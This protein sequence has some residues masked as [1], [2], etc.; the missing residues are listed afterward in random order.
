MGNSSVR[1]RWRGL[2]DVD[3]SW[4]GVR[5]AGVDAR[6]RLNERFVVEGEASVQ[7]N[8]ETGTDRSVGRGLLRYEN[9]SFTASTGLSYA[10]DEFSDGETR[11]SELA[12]V[13]VTQKLF[14]GRLTLRANANVANE[15]DAE[16]SDYPTILVIGADY[17]LMDGLDLFAEWEDSSSRD[18]EATMTKLGVRASP[19]SRAQ[20]NSSVT[21]ETTEFGPRVFANLGLTQG[22]QLNNN[23]YIDVGVDQTNTI[24]QPG[25][26]V[27]DTDSEL[28]SG[29]LNEDFLAAY[30]GAMYNAELWSANTRIEH[31]NSDTEE[32]ITLLSGWYREPRMGH[33]LSAGLTMFTS[34][35]ISGAETTAA[36]L[37]FGW[38]YRV[39]GGQWSFLNRI[40]LVFEETGTSLNLE[41][42][43]RFINNLNANRRLSEH[44]QIS[45]QYAFK[46]VKSNFNGL[47]LSGYTDLIGADY[48]RALTPK[49]DIGGHT[50][51]YRSYQSDVTDYGF[52]LS[53]AYNLRDNMWLTIGY[54]AF[55]FD[56]DDFAAARYTAQ[57]PYLQFTIK[58]DQHTL[59][60]IAG[61]SQ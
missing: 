16:N 59:K 42:S 19:W 46:Y 50:S 1:N 21:N 31:R 8:L 28:V 52:G 35:N 48:H 43:W 37:R 6:I 26:R 15:E 23:W 33:S 18:I 61:Q 34:E 29:S 5:K 25:A 49:W 53:L 60:R 27:F 14:G 57:G 9:G 12:E 30:I 58:A 11:T 32:R 54:N 4:A 51:I 45:L 10:E 17:R 38:A 24:V 22:I 47:Q 39:P 13:G 3:A 40:D 2:S 44:S 55:G 20:I 56:D 41:D 7:Q 36:D